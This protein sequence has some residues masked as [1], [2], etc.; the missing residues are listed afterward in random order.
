VA[1]ENSVSEVTSVEADA[2]RI[3]LIHDALD[4]LTTVDARLTQ[5]VECRFFAGYSEEETAEILGVS[6]RTVRRDWLRARA[7]LHELM[8]SADE[9]A[10]ETDLPE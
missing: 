1:N 6:S 2:D 9:S 3:L 4:R 5:V 8:K 7:W 10:A